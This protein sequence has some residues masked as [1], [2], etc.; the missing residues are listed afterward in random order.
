MWPHLDRISDRC[1]LIALEA[2]LEVINWTWFK[3]GICTSKVSI[4]IHR[5]IYLGTHMCFI[6]MSTYTSYC[7]FVWVRVV[8]VQS[9]S[10][11]WVFATPWTAALQ[12]SLSS[13]ISQSLLKVMSSELM[14]LSN[15]LILLS[16]CCRLFLLPSIFPNIRVSSNESA[17]HIRWP[18]YIYVYMNICMCEYMYIY[19]CVSIFILI[20]S[21]GNN[22]EK[23][24]IIVYSFIPEIISILSFIFCLTFHQTSCSR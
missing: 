21:F 24:R 4:Y 9:L 14:M 13:T 12:A 16:P 19:E 15:H 17:L 8:V 20:Y 22:F 10:C 23:S 3:T 18:K 6:F 7:I 5:Y 11:V 1:I 2:G